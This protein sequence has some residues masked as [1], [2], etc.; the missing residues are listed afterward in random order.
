MTEAAPHDVK[1]RRLTT[2]DSSPQGVTCLTDLPCG[3][4]AH[5]ASFL[6]APSKALF[7]IA[8]DENSAVTINE[9]SSAIV[10]NNWDT[11]DFGQIEKEVAE[12][13]S[14]ADIERVLLHIDA[15]NKLKRLKLTNCT[16]IFGTCLEPLRGS[17]V[18]EFLDLSLVDYHQN[19]DLDLVPPISCEHVL[20]VLDSV[21]ESTQYFQFPAKWRSGFNPEFSRFLTRLNRMWRHRDTPICLECE[22]DLPCNSMEWFGIRNPGYQFGIQRNT[23]SVCLKHYCDDCIRYHD[24]DEGTACVIDYCENCD[25]IFCMECSTVD[26][27]DCCEKVFCSPC[28]NMQDCDGSECSNDICD[29]CIMDHRQ[30]SVCEEIFCSECHSEKVVCCVCCQRYNCHDCIEGWRRCS[31]GVSCCDDCGVSGDVDKVHFC[32]KVF[33]AAIR[34]DLATVKSL[35]ESGIDVIG[36]RQDDGMSSI[37]LACRNGHTDLVNYLLEQGANPNDSENFGG[38]C[39]VAAACFRHPD[40]VRRLIDAGADVEYS[41][42]GNNETIIHMTAYC[43]SKDAEEGVL[44]F[45]EGSVIRTVELLLEAG[46]PAETSALQLLQE[47]QT[48]DDKVRRER[49]GLITFLQQEI[50]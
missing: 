8:L 3:I 21:I 38:T 36:R 30:C 28:R 6:A 27:C 44:D 12:K 24:D 47:L 39:L 17:A 34:G 20:P 7:A 15:V 48:S 13:L 18:I 23:C 11:L 35:H 9:R 45:E 10:G 4:L 14:D 42:P 49:D 46:A 16:N 26:F 25:R 32:H 22:E 41:Y 31:C 29:G 19:P 40:C 43:F 33:N 5:A 50:S 1:R 2:A 37:L